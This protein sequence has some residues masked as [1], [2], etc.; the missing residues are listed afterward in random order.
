MMITRWRRRSMQTA[1]TLA[2]VGL[3]SSGP[4]QADALPAG[5]R[6]VSLA[7]TVAT[8]D[9]SVRVAPPADVAETVYETIGHGE[10]SYYGHELAGNRTASGER[11]NPNG[12]T[13]AHRTLPLGSK[14]RVTN[15]ANGRSVIVRVNDRG[16]FVRSRLIDVSLGAAREIQM[17]R[18][19]KA[20][21][22]LELL[23]TI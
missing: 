7:E 23:P 11:F 9:E 19:G 16:P 20:Q 14:V 3:M 2:L 17:V 8:L 10:A 5:D 1:V 12:L 4:V 13:A 21:V 15:M 18:S 22:R 6:L